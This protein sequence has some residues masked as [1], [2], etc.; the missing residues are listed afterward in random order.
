MAFVSDISPT[1]W[2]DLASGIGALLGGVA[3][4]LTAMRARDQVAA[5]ANAAGANPP[6]PEPSSADTWAGVAIG[7]AIAAFV[8]ACIVVERSWVPNSPAPQ[9]VSLL[10]LRLIALCFGV[11]ATYAG[12]N[13]VRHRTEQNKGKFS[14]LAVVTGFT[15]A[16]GMSV[17]S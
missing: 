8:I 14:G 2:G 13:A 3:A 6:P 17:I 1:T 5:Q 12:L 16:L 15:V 7:L 4:V 9:G 10:P 11:L